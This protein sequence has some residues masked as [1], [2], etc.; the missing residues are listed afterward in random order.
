MT[1]KEQLDAAAAAALDA[2]TTSLQKSALDPDA[3][4]CGKIAALVAAANGHAAE[5]GHGLFLAQMCATILSTIAAA[6][7]LQLDFTAEEAAA[8]A[9]PNTTH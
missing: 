4:E 8:R 3:M 6:G 9:V 1:M 7:I 2:V 5:H